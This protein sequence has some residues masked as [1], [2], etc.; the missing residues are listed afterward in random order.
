MSVGAVCT[1]WA[2]IYLALAEAR[3]LS[4]HPK[5]WQTAAYSSS[6]TRA[7]AEYRSRERCRN[8]QF[9]DIFQRAGEAISSSVVG[10][11]KRHGAVGSRVTRVEATRRP[12]YQCI[13]LNV[14]R[15]QG[16]RQC[17][18]RAATVGQR[19]EKQRRQKSTEVAAAGDAVGARAFRPACRAVEHEREEEEEKYLKN[20]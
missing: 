11:I 2:T 1:R 10:E 6:I 4:N 17:A 15:G 7:V 12:Y 20:H 14:V 19:E 16:G 9:G 5:S 3:S 18:G 13:T 8:Q